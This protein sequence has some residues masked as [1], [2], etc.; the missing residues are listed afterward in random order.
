M[1]HRAFNREQR[2]VDLNPLY[3][4]RFHCW[5]CV[6]TV[7]VLWLFVSIVLD[8]NAGTLHRTFDFLFWQA[9]VLFIVSLC[10]TVYYSYKR[11]G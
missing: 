2:E 6:Y 1:N 9:F 8:R 4:K 3:K 11:D 7:S 10:L 5:L